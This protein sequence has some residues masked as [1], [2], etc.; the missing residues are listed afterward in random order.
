[1]LEQGLVE[2]ASVSPDGCRVAYGFRPRLD[3]GIPEG[4][5]RLVVL[6]LCGA[7]PIAKR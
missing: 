4:G 7:I 6:D 3:T 1:M 2:E 5:P